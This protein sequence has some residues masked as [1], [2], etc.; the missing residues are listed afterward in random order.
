M[1]ATN[2]VDIL[3][4]AIIRP[5]RFDRV[6]QVTLPNIN[7][8]TDIFKV[9]LDK[10]KLNQERTKNEY[11]KILASLTP[12]FSG[13]EISNVVNEGAIIAARNNKENVSI[14]EFEKATER[15]VGGIEK[16]KIMTEVERKRIAYHEAGHA[17]VGW[18]SQFSY[19]LMKVSI[20]PRSKGAFGFAQYLP[21]EI[22]L[23]SKE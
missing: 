23:Y 18:F 3:D 1:G 2:R 5:G 8:R 4:P 14:D 22:S 12:G 21:N 13:A 7:E 20:I 15:V 9:C 16:K 6:I 19:P 10:I 11:S 17:I